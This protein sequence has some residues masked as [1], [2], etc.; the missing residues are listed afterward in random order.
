MEGVHGG[1]GVGLKALGGEWLY[2]VYPRE[3]KVVSHG[4]EGTSFLLKI[5]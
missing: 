3:G 5:R 4:P 2:I 1:T